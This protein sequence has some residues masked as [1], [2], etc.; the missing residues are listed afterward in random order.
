MGKINEA[1]QDFETV[2]LLEPGNKQAVTELSRIKKELIEK[3][4]WDD[5]FLDSTQRHNVV[6]LVDKPARGSPKALKKV[7]I[8][9]TGSLIE[10]VDAP[11]SSST[12]SESDGAPAAA[13]TESMKNSSQGVSLPAGD[14]PRAKVLKIEAVSATLAPQAQVEVKQDVRQPLS[15][16]ASVRVEPMPG[17]LATAVLPPVPA[18]SFQLES[19]FRQLRS[20]PEMLYQYVKKIEPSLYP[21]LFQK[22]LDPDVFNQIIKILHGFYIEREKP[23]LI[24]EVLE[25]LSQLR[26][27]EMAVMF[28][29]GP[30]RKLTNELFN[31]LEKSELKDHSVEEL[32]K[33]YGG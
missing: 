2:L 32:K 28:M 18:N 20:S 11:D 29:S 25:R 6:K 31:Y 21:K 13:G 3:G 30:E 16:K 5:V 1:K 24:F 9:E 27:F 10:T 17:Q 33:R 8:E 26:R 12:V 14:T 23:T 19:D 15:E 7:F 4:R 22:N